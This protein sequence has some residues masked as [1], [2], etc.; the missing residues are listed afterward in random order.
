MRNVLSALAAAALLLIPAIAAA[1][2]IVFNPVDSVLLGD[3]DDGYR[4]VEVTGRTGSGEST[5]IVLLAYNSGG[6]MER[7]RIEGCYRQAVIAMNKPGRWRFTATARLIWSGHNR[8]Y[9]QQC[10]LSRID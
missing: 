4:A 5:T 2:T 1:D 3:P 8:Y 7:D 6:D 10:G 9:I